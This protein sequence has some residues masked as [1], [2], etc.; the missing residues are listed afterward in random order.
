L[1]G[2][3]KEYDSY[4]FYQNKIAACDKEIEKFIKEELKKDPN[5]K[6]INK[7]DLKPEEIGIIT[8]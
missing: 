4:K 8:N 6:Q 5:K 7:F 3:K 2:L 1:F